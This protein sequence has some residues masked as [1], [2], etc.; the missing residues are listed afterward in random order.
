M[1][2]RRTAFLSVILVHCLLGCHVKRAATVAAANVSACPILLHPPTHCC[3]ILEIKLSGKVFYPTDEEYQ[4]QQSSYYSAEQADMTPSCRV[5]PTTADDV[6]LIVKTARENRCT[7][8][9]RSGGHMHYKGA[10]NIDRSGFTVDMQMLNSVSLSSDMTV[11]TVGPGCTWKMVYDFLSPHHLTTAGGRASSVGVGGFLLGGGLSYLSHEFGFASESIRAYEIV[12]ADATIVVATPHSHNEL[13]WALKYGSTNFGI[14][15]RFEM[16]TYS[17]ND[18]I[19]G[20]SAFYEIS[21]VLP[22]METLVNFTANLAEDPKGMSSF[23]IGWSPSEQEYIVCS[24]N[25]YLEPVAFPPLFSD[26]ASFNPSSSTFRFTS[27][28]DIADEVSQF[29]SG[30]IRVKWL[31]LTLKPN[32]QILVDLHAYGATLF[33][34]LQ[35]HP[36][37]NFALNSQP[38]NA[39]L[40]GASRTNSFGMTSKDG[41]LILVLA[42]LSWTDPEDDPIFTMKF[43]EYSEWAEGEVRR[44]GLHER[45][46][47]MNYASGGKDVMG[48]I[49][50]EN[51]DRMKQVRQAYDPDGVFRRYWKGGF[52]L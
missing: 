20:G 48:Y 41:D 25:I 30:G 7:F 21:L 44:R 6:S 45:F 13:F 31:T 51:L 49:G 11:T 47:Y 1:G 42:T 32:A 29:L 33:Q 19:W 5:S 17:L 50:D 46:M 4:R 28:T 27:L 37:F 18:V 39:G 26:L 35:R 12:L 8:A 9:V 2:L 3:T 14:V 43:H 36:G 15:T 38:I 10:S 52:K 40:V 24:V 23:G 16:L 34:P 22:L